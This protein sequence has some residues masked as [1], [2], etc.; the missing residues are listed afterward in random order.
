MTVV[1]VDLK[2]TTKKTNYFTSPSSS[3]AIINIST[4]APSPCQLVTMNTNLCL[5]AN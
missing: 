1:D 2:K 3:S 5:Y 4:Q